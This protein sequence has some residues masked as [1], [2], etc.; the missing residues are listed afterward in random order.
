MGRAKFTLVNPADGGKGVL[1]KDVAGLFM[2][3]NH[4]FNCLFIFVIWL[5]STFLLICTFHEPK[6]KVNAFLDV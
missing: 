3:L 6:L 1:F 4:R 5:N 2:K